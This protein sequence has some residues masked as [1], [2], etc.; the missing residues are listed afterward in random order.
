MKIY[1]KA[2]L[3]QSIAERV[4][5]QGGTAYFVGGCVRDKLLGR[6]NKDIDIEIHD[7]PSDTLEA[8][9]SGFGEVMKFGASFGVY[10]IKGYD[11]DFA[12]PRT[13]RK[14]GEKHTDFEI[15]SD[16]YMSTEKASKR[17]DFTINALMEN[18]LTGEITD[19]W[20]GRE[21]LSAGIIRHVDDVTFKEDTLRVLRAAQF[22][23]RF[24]FDIAEETL[25]S[26]KQ[27]SL[28][29]LSRERVFAETEKALMKAE[30]PS[31][32]FEQLRRM[33]QLGHWFPE[34]K[35]LIGAEQNEQYHREGDV[36]NHTMLVLDEAAKLRSKAKQP[37]FFML[38]ALCHDLGKPFAATV[39]ENGAVHTYGH[40][41][42]GL[43]IAEKFL[44]RLTSDK[45]LIK[46]VLN[47]TELHMQPNIKA[48]N[49][50]KIK[51]T[52]KMFDLSVEPYD[53]I[54]LSECDSLGKLPV[55][56]SNMDFLLD[57]LNVFYKMMQEPYVTGE[58]LIA[59]GLT[60]CDEFSDILGYAHKLRLAGVNKE[61]AL[62]QTLSYARKKGC[63][64]NDNK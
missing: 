2:E 41:T 15:T 63:V 61:H 64:S 44:E 55:S 3:V 59:A 53:L 14:T 13:E 10:N 30:K 26:C 34:L 58:D 4:R 33:G 54:L 52:N 36:W 22:S 6:E 46:Y 57:R 45:R 48:A 47:M 17:R 62:T 5:E 7:I 27:L 35:D 20:H 11:I 23:A 43:P 16:P 51:S 38:S 40:E 29:E 8:V 49:K 50:S 28:S 39:G 56:E 31:I 12:L 19:H 60:P 37:L 1:G 24:E 9:L 18:V 25:G 21:D 32:F 42:E